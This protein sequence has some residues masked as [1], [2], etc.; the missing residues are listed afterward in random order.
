VDSC[1]GRRVDSVEERVRVRKGNRSRCGC[2]P[3][4]LENGLL[5][6]SIPQGNRR[7]RD[8]SSSIEGHDGLF[9]QLES[10]ASILL[11]ILEVLREERARQGGL[12]VRVNIR[13]AGMS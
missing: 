12:F 8:A 5:R 6:Q 2:R 10:S 1:S 9:R 13:W 3:R 11:G 7:P 4:L